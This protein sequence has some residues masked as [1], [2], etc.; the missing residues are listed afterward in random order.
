MYSINSRKRINFL[1]LVIAL[2]LFSI[3]STGTRAYAATFTVA[4]TNDDGAGSLRYSVSQADLTTEE[5]TIVFD[6]KVFSTPKT[7]T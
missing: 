5:D 3:I 7:I 6:V 2:V 1:F 4:N